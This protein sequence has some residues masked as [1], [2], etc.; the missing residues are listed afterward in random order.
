MEVQAVAKSLKS[1]DP[2]RIR[3]SDPQLRRLMLYPTELRGRNSLLEHDLSEN[4][5]PLFGIVL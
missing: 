5:F 3:T 1:G 4:R 2:G